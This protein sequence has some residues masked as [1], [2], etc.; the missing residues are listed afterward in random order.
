[1]FENLQKLLNSQFKEDLEIEFIEPDF[2]FEPITEKELRE[3]ERHIYI[4][5][6]HENADIEAYWCIH[7]GMRMH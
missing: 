4:A 5:K 6:G 1:L 3:D 2:S 7:F